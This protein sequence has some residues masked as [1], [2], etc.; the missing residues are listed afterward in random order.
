MTPEVVRALGLFVAIV[1]TAAFVNR[2]APTA[3]PR[4][5]AIAMLFVLYIIGLGAMHVLRAVD[6]QQWASRIQ[7]AT[8]IL[9]VLTIITVAGTIMFRVLFRSVGIALPT[10]AGDLIVGLG[11]IVATVSVLSQHGLDPMGA[12][13]TGAVVSAVL[14]ISLQTTLGNILGGVALQLD[15]SIHEGDWIQLE[16]GK[17]GRV[18]AIRWRHTLVE[19]RDWSTIVVPNAQLLQNNITVLGWRDDAV[20]PQ[21]MWV[22]FNVDFRYSPQR[23]IEVVTEGLRASP[24]ENVAEDPLPNC[25]CMDFAKEGRDSYASYAVRYWILDLDSDDPTN[26]RVRTRVFTALRRA[27][28]PLATPAIANLV[29]VRD[30]NREQTHVERNIEA[31]VDALRAVKLFQPLTDPELRGIAESLSPVIYT[32]NERI[33]KQGAIA[34][35]LYIL[36]RGRVDIITRNA[37][38]RQAE[39]KVVASLEAPEVFGELGVMTGEP[40]GADVVARTDVEC[41]RLGKPAFERVLTARPQVAT[42]FA[43]LLASRREGLVDAKDRLD[44]DARKTR[45]ARERD[46]ILG[47]IRAFFGL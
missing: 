3:R 21:R 15:G 33:A 27:G 10:I 29:E 18:R 32:A 11:Y 46:K 44:E 8:E 42:E 2:F 26:S 17:Q 5:R 35:H 1:V 9:R 20:A 30:R 45:H 37:E 4:L 34:H 43:E 19:T 31:R 47:S 24:I 39:S 6:E 28:I 40:R 22:W 12:L 25:V 7:I 23:V 13:A 14:A 36:T 38:G 41:L 16:N